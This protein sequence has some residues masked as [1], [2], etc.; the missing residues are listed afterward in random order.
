MNVKLTLDEEVLDGVIVSALTESI[1]LNEEHLKR[2]KKKKKLSPHEKEDLA[3]CIYT[4]DALKRTR[5]YYGGEK[6]AC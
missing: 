6:Y 2:I 1:I 3:D 5:Y 4:L